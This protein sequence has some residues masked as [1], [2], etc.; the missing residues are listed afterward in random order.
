MVSTSWE[1][2]VPGRC[3]PSSLALLPKM[4]SCSCPE[5]TRMEDVDATD[6]TD[7]TREVK[8]QAG[9]EAIGMVLLHDGVVRGASRSGDPVAA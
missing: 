6:I 1:V 9:S 4:N 3:T 5:R 8:A 7:W 2:M